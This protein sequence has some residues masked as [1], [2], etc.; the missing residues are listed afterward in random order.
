MYDQNLISTKEMENVCT[1]DIECVSNFIQAIWNENLYS[2][3]SS[4]L[5]DQF[6]DHS[7]PFR[8][9]QNKEGLLVYLK[10]MTA[11]ISHFTDILELRKIHDFV[12]CKI[13]I[14]VTDLS[15]Y[16]DSNHE[17]IEGFRLFKMQDN[18]IIA[19]WEML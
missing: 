4:Y 15:D 13:R 5:H 16:A 9:L 18:R 3:I 17:I 11:R 19:H 1:R 14:R 6:I 8:F 10:A 12:F 2:E 7:I